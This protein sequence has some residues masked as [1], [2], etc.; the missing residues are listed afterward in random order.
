MDMLF[1]FHLEWILQDKA[2][3]LDFSV[4]CLNRTKRDLGYFEKINFA[5]K[6]ATKYL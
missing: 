1:S 2:R 5:I 4:K 6:Q 3:V